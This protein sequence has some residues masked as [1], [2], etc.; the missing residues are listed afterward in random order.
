M[1]AR[2]RLLLIAFL[3]LGL[4]L[5]S[6]HYLRAPS[7]WQDEAAIVLNILN[8]SYGELLGPL[9]LH[10]AAPP[11]FLWLEKAVCACLGDGP[12]AFRLPPYLA[13]CAALF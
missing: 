1:S 5:R 2:N 7:V 12:Y 9:S 10:Q 8:K 4:A 11:L 3:A 6:W 13:S